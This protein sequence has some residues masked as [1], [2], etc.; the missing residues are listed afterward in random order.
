MVTVHGTTLKY[1]SLLDRVWDLIP[2]LG[3]KSCDMTLLQE[4]ERAIP[5]ADDCDSELTLATQNALICLDCSLRG[6]SDEGKS[7]AL[8]V[9]Y[10]FDALASLISL[11]ETGFVEPGSGLEEVKLNEVLIKDPTILL[12]IKRQER[13]V[14]ELGTDFTRE[15][16]RY[17]QRA[18]EEAYDL[19]DVYPRG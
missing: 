3:G 13:D 11:R 1:R 8:A 14:S 18:E 7:F 10:S 16:L 15:L 6:F 2:Q 9:E 17:K 4:I 5:H 19:S 12:E